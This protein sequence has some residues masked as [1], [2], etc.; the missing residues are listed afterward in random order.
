MKYSVYPDIYSYKDAPDVLINNFNIKDAKK[1]EK[2]EQLK[3]NFQAGNF[4]GYP[5]GSFDLKHFQ[6][7]HKYLFGEV[8]PWAGEI[9]Q[10]SISKG[11]SIFCTPEYIEA[12]Y[13]NIY[14]EIVKDNYLK[15]VSNNALPEHL[16]YYHGEINMVHPF[17]E[18]NGR[19]TRAFLD[20]MVFTSKGFNLDYENVNK[21][22]FIEASIDSSVFNYNKMENIYKR[23]IKESIK[24]IK[25]KQKPLGY[26]R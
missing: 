11:E 10:I 5:K 13:K 17:R 8:Y 6:A 24:E 15:K 19:T 3:V 25:P 16:A 22:E 4:Q 7:L 18:G 12:S 2:L 21:K 14:K 9:R 26:D 23:I 20:L 1:L